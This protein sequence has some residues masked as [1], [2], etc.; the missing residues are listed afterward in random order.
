MDDDGIPE[1]RT[2]AE[3]RAATAAWAP[4]APGSEAVTPA[5]VTHGLQMKRRNPVV[6]WIVWPL[7]TLGIYHL[8]W[9]YKIH[10]E[11]G[12]FDPRRHVPD[13]GPLLVLILLGWTVIAPLVSY[14]NCGR[15]IENS[16]RAAGLTP[17]CAPLVGMLLMLVLG[18]G[19]LYYQV[20]LNR[21]HDSYGP[22]TPAG[23]EVPLR[24]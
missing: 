2:P 3:E 8:V 19:T 16:Q 23:T 10:H 13:V 11:M 14:Y 12:T 7:I 5:P 17:T 4:A 24:A 20:E 15:R 22:E 21:V 6:T 9:Y 1:T 18:L